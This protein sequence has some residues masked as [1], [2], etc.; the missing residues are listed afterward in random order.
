MIKDLQTY[1]QIEK[2]IFILT[3][4]E[5]MVI[6][7]GKYYRRSKNFNEFAWGLIDRK[8]SCHQV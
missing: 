5:K 6:K 7:I 2:P 8:L 1:L 3:I 4:Q